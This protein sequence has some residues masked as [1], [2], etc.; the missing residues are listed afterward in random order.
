MIIINRVFMKEPNSNR[1][2]LNNAIMLIA[3][4]MEVCSSDRHT[5]C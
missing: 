3:E 5:F 2:A 1:S 4:S